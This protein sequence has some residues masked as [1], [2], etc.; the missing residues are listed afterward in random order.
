MKNLK[1]TNSMT[2]MRKYLLL[3]A[4]LC[5]LLTGCGNLYTGEETLFNP[6]L[7]EDVREE[8]VP[9]MVAFDDPYYNILSRGVGKI[10]P[11]DEWFEG[12]MNP[13]DP[14]TGLPLDPKMKPRFFIYAFRKANNYG[15]RVTRQ[16][17]KEICLI[18]GSTGTQG[19]VARENP[20]EMLEGHGKLAY[21]NGNGSFVNWLYIENDLFYS[22]NSP[23]APYDF[24]AYHHGGAVSGPVTRDE[25][26]ISFPVDIDG[27]QDLMCG[28][29]ALTEEQLKT[30]SEL[31]D[32]EEKQKINEFHYSTYTGQRNIWPVFRL[33]HQMAYVKFN[34][35][36]GNAHG[37]PVRVHEVALET[38]T[39]GNFVVVDRNGNIGATFNPN[40]ERKWLNIR[41]LKDGSE[42]TP[43]RWDEITALSVE[44]GGYRLE[45]YSE[46]EQLAN[47]GKERPDP[48]PAGELLLPPGNETMLRMKLSNND[49][50]GKPEVTEISLKGQFGQGEGL[51]A[52]RT[53][54]LNITV[55]GPKQISIEVEASP[56][57]DGGDVDVDIEENGK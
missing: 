55:Y 28:M 15:Y 19:E 5:L 41:H 31:E 51:V 9:I 33:R 29:A 43:E 4:L 24:F 6:A 54:N 26:R 53:Y 49:T 3:Q 8:Q 17:D 34:L 45:Y 12:K 14:E 42:L 52:G 25:N 13:T 44:E 36:A 46:E 39:Q 35:L 56:W 47:G 1:E 37:D 30:I 27:S 16:D 32:E 22:Q 50:F 48:Y 11:E 10:D 38:H 23:N 20:D 57:K 2:R 21:Y 40:S 18:D 7:G